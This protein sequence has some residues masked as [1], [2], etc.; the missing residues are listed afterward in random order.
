MK[1]RSKKEIT[2]DTLIGH[3]NE[4]T[5]LEIVE[6]YLN[7]KVVSGN[8]G[9]ELALGGIQRKIRDEKDMIKFLEEYTKEL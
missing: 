1:I 8:K 6:V 2:K 7:R 4:L 3:K 5:G 9:T